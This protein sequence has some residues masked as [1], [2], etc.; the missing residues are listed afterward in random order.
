LALL[1]L[2]LDAPWLAG[3]SGIVV[4]RGRHFKNAIQQKRLFD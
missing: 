3:T 1:A 4:R 2:S